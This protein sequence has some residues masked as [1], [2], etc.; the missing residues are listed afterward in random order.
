MAAS[1][2]DESPFELLRPSVRAVPGASYVE[3]YDKDQFVAP[4]VEANDRFF[5]QRGAA[6]VQ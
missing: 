6:A 3:L 2:N 1:R 5:K 4:A